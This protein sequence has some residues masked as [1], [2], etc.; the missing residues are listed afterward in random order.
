MGLPTNPQEFSL[1]QQEKLNL[2]AREHLHLKEKII[3]KLKTFFPKEKWIQCESI[4]KFSWER[5]KDNE[6]TLEKLQK[7]EEILKDSNTAKNDRLI[8]T[9]RDR[10]RDWYISRR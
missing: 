3:D 6:Y 4:R 2:R 1:E 5:V 8:R 7:I 9:L 10:L